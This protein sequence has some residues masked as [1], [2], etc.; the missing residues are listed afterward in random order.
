MSSTFDAGRAQGCLQHAEEQV[1]QRFRTGRVCAWLPAMRDR[2]AR[3]NTCTDVTAEDNM[4]YFSN[5]EADR[6]TPKT[7][8]VDLAAL[9]REV[10]D[11]FSIHAPEKNVTFACT[12]DPGLPACIATDPTRLRQILLNLL[13]N[14]HQF[15][16]AGGFALRVSR[17]ASDSA[18]MLR[19]D[20]S[21]TGIGISEADQAR[22]FERFVPADA[23]TTRKDH[24]TG[25]GLAISR[26]LARLLG[27]DIAIA[28]RPGVGSTF[29]LM[30]PL[31]EVQATPRSNA[32]AARVDA[33]M[34]GAVLVVEDNAVNQ[35][36]AR[37]L[38][39]ALG[40]DD[41]V[42]AGDGRQA[43]QACAE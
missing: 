12:V 22:L 23:S 11:V 31:K 19:F 1:M 37:G 26:Q 30:I 13:G 15:T 17:V 42:V 34:H 2:L 10:S 39:N 27:G 36:V 41:V 25:L 20:V 8:P 16:T 7:T 4:P 38:P 32:K 40:F 9:V 18:A 5:T 6:V 21:D 24:G 33:P 43:V 28:S 35:L 29:T 14:A 3:V